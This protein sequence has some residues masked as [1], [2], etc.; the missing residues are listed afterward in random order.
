MADSILRLTRVPATGYELRQTPSHGWLEFQWLGASYSWL[1][2]TADWSSGSWIRL[3]GDTILW[4]TGV[5]VARYELQL[6]PSYSWI[7]VAAD[8]IVRL[9]RVPLAGLD[10][11]LL[12][13][14]IYRVNLRTCSAEYIF[15]MVCFLQSDFSYHCFRLC[16]LLQEP[17]RSLE[18]LEEAWRSFKALAATDS[19]CSDW[20]EL[21]RLIRDLRPIDYLQNFNLDAPW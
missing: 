1:H 11:R 17:W 18:K 13:T 15:F 12:Y 14:L 9:T 3:K 6:I 5:L 16:M 19:S 20:F 8:Y 2:P 7:R 4:L 21:R 10:L